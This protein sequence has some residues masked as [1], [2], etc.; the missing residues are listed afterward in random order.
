MKLINLFGE[1]DEI[2]AS[3]E[4]PNIIG[5][6]KSGGYLSNPMIPAHGITEGKKCKD[7]IFVYRREFAKRYYKCEKRGKPKASVQND[8]K[9]KW[10]ACGLFQENEK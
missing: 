7:C 1:V 6:N 3:T 8:H 2:K 10:D 5:R 9:L 4:K